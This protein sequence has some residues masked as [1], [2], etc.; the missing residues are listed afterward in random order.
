VPTGHALCR[1]AA[2]CGD[3][4]DPVLVITF[5]VTVAV[6]LITAVAVGVA[7]AVV[8]ALRSVS[9]S[10][11]LEQVPLGPIAG[12]A[13]SID[14]EE[15]ELLTQHIVAYRIDGPL[16][17]AAAHRFLLELTEIATVRV[18]ILRLSR[19]TSL[20]VTAARVLGD[21]ISR[22]ENRGIIVLLSGIRPEHDDILS[23]LGVADHLRADHRIFADTPTAIASARV[24][25]GRTPR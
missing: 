1:P 25:I 11:Q 24:L 19:I 15:Y 7:I 2:P 18:V 13:A 5:L 22:L 21:A 14:A 23:T 12:D 16:F 6:D 8:L 9:R 4:P 17:F 20:D 10:V 3:R